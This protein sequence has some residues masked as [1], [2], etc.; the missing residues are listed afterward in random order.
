METILRKGFEKILSIFYADK[1]AR[2]HLREIASRAGLNENSASRFLNQLEKMKIL[3]SEKDGNQK[4]YS[5][6][7]NDTT[8]AFFSLFD[9][10]RLD[11][12]PSIRKNAVLYFIRELKE[13][14][15]IIIVFGSTAKNNFSDRSD[16]DLLLIVNR[17]IDV[18]KARK[19]T[20]SQTALDVNALQITYKDF[21]VE[22]K[23]KEDHVV[24]SAIKTGYPVSNHMMFY[25][26]VFG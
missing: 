1:T 8:Y 22:M 5:L 17:K 7:H 9:T 26:E 12:L 18:E 3:R 19:Y 13:K 6:E 23:L 14:P 21:L 10:R 24:Q 20:D 4:K 2:I 11:A 16:V 25:R 15:V